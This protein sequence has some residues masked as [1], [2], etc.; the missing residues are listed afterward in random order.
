MGTR[1]GFEQEGG[2]DFK[3][4]EY[5]DTSSQIIVNYNKEDTVSFFGTSFEYVDLYFFSQICCSGKTN[6]QTQKVP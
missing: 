4:K 3:I 1:A 2:C 5:Q 6:K